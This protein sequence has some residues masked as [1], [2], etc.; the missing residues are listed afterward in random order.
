MFQ[1]E[2]LQVQML[3]LAHPFLCSAHRNQ[4]LQHL[5]VTR[6]PVAKFWLFLEFFATIK[7]L[8]LEFLFQGTEAAENSPHGD[9]NH[10][11]PHQNG[12]SDAM[13]I[14]PGYLN[15]NDYQVTLLPKVM[16]LIVLRHLLI[17]CATHTHCTM[18]LKC[19]FTQD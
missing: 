4:I 15:T 6:T 2:F 19:L 1:S 18:I 8:I 14:H 13:I 5:K 10:I 16:I 3:L 12:H 17:P 11:I 9:I 7:Y